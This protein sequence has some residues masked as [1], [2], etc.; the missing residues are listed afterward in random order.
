MTLNQML[1]TLKGDPDWIFL[2][3][4]FDRSIPPDGPINALVDESLRSMKDP[5]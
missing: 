3:N 1:E 2:T 5:E 4:T